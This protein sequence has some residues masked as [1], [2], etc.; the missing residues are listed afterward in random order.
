MNK[1]TPFSL[2]RL[3]IG[4]LVLA[5]TSVGAGMLAIPVATGGF[6]IFP[7]ATTTIITWLLMMITGLMFLEVNLWMP[8][9][10]NLTSMAQKYLGPSGKVISI[11]SFLF[12]YYC[13]EVSYISGG[14]QLFS[15]MVKDFLG[16]DLSISMATIC[17]T[18]V[19]AF[20]AVI[21]TA[22]AGQINL[23]LMAALILTYTMIIVLGF[24]V[25]DSQNLSIG[26]W[27]EAYWAF[28]VL[29]GAFGYHNIIPTLCNYH[30]RQ[31]TE[32]RLAIILGTTITLVI[33]LLWQWIV[34]GALTSQQI[35]LTA[36]KDIPISITLAQVVEHAQLP[37]FILIYSS[38]A[39]ITSF[40]GV[41]LSMIDF[42]SD[43]LGRKQTKLLRVILGF[44]TFVPSAFWA[45]KHPN[46]FQSAIAVAGG[47]GESI[48][49]AIIPALMLFIGVYYKQ[50]KATQQWITSKALIAAIFIFSA[51][52]FFLEVIE[53]YHF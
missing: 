39:L 19:V 23:I 29:F 53:I 3:L 8:K 49:N 18:G 42:L 15:V 5:G 1:A 6:G 24:D 45:L 52:I 2:Y 27:K 41:S 21:G 34:I 36:Q 26:K 31:A 50:M 30:K 32:L 10:A 17:F 25:V 9:E 11:I 46:V 47:I 28:P 7:A 40:L 13:L 38:C 14:S 20:I 35:A 43:M 12:L 16:L 37:L 4:T 44:V 51:L 22:L 33:Y 48:L